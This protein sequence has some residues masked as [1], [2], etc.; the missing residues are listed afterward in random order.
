MSS[1]APGIQRGWRWRPDADDRNIARLA[2]PALGALAAEPLYVL[3]DT[4]I[5]GH[6][7]V[8][9]LA[10]LALA[11]GAISSVVG[12]FS[13]L[14]FG[15]T[16]LVGR[17]FAVGSRDAAGHLGR[18]AT[19]L[20]GALGVLLALIAIAA[21]PAV[22]HLLGGHGQAGRLAGG[23]LR[24][25]ALGL[26]FALTALA[27]QGYLRGVA[28]LRLPLLVLLASNLVNLA[29][30]LWFVNGLEWGIAGSAWG[31][32]IAQ[33]T[34]ATAFIVVLARAP[35]TGPLIDLT[36]LRSLASTG[37]QIFVRS[38]TLTGTFL[39]A[40]VLLAHV[41][42]TAL[43]AHQIAFQ[44][45]Y[46]LALTLSALA[47][48]AQVLVSHQIAVGDIEPARQLAQRI[49]IWSVTVGCCFTI[50]LLATG[51]VL[52]ELFTQ[53]P[54]VVDRAQAVWPILALMQPFNALAFALDGILLGA[55]DTRFC[56]RAMPAAAATG[57]APLAI[58]ST[59]L[60]WGIVGIWLALSGLIIARLMIYMPRF[61]G[62]TW[63]DRP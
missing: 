43:G 52:P 12:L 18:Q 47:I 33:V 5:V 56:M 60:G 50:L 15:S 34:T 7:G 19:L 38:V 53:S 61:L 1:A 13:F 32:V 20:A 45:W 30:E 3:A 11:G 41:G 35:S 6:L 9:A 36:A 42:S 10:A 63:L 49:L 4:A 23:Y 48:A 46:L 8:S 24:I 31:T 29:L 62:E 54:A 37:A 40:N 55:G 16:T 51:P 26:P 22:I 28:S 59:L 2:L 27:I 58:L 25:A 57:F 39:I 14:T 17:L 21:A 44:L